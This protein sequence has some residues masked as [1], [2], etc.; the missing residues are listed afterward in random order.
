[1][2][3]PANSAS[4][5]AYVT[6][7][8]ML[9]AMGWTASLLLPLLLL[10]TGWGARLRTGCE[11][12][13][14]GNRY[15]TLTLFA[16]CY[17]VLNALVLL[18]VHF[19]RRIVVEQAFG[20]PGMTPGALLWGDA[21]PL[22]VQIVVAALALWIPFTLLQR[23]PRFWWLWSAL[24]IVPI[25][26]LVL[27]ALPVFVDPL[28][29]DFKPLAD[30]VLLAKIET[31]TARCG[32]PHVPVMVGGG[33]DTVVGLGP[34]NRIVLEEDIRRHETD[35]QIEFTAGHELKHYLLG[36][37]WKALAIVAVFALAGLWLVDRGGR[38]ILARWH[39]RLGFEELSDPAAL[40]LMVLILSVFWLAV[41]PAFNWEARRIESEADRFGLEL[42]HQNRA[43]A[44]L[45]AKWAR[46][47]IMQT[48]YDL[49]FRLFR[50][51][52]PS[53]GERIRFA[54][55]Y[56]PWANGGPLRYG[57]I[58]QPSR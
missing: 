44:E 35:D 58:C 18:P 20:Q 29:T 51:T 36:D 54:N 6:Q 7:A 21:V 34:T 48:D 40:P 45:F 17:L 57:D 56:R 52:H 24:A 39:R 22:L 50:Q 11:R 9:W 16:I 43:A 46:S 31:L 19:W 47:G 3:V 13:A 55:T 23:S 5:N 53:L 8:E 37:N 30:K 38:R 4:A 27:V 1:V 41:L 12:L 25:A 15:F 2:P 49:F 26:F 10:L 32:I 28:T 14:R 33:D 42:T